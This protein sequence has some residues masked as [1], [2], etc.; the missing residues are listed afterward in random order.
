MNQDELRNQRFDRSL[1]EITKRELVDF[2]RESLER[3]QTEAR[4]NEAEKAIP[5]ELQHAAPPR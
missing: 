3:R 2:R 5:T 1:N 4:R